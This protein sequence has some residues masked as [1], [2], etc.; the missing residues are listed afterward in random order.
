MDSELLRSMHEQNKERS[1]EFGVCV[2]FF[3]DCGFGF[4]KLD[5]GSTDIFV[6]LRCRNKNRSLWAR[7]FALMSLSGFVWM[8]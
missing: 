7:G 8:M 4:L 3:L 1:R 5:D 6:H 2:R